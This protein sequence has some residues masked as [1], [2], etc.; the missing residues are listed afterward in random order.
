[1]PWC[2]VCCNKTNNDGIICSHDYINK[3]N[4]DKYNGLF[5]QFNIIVLNFHNN[6]IESSEIK[7]FL[8]QL[9]SLHNEI[10]KLKMEER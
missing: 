6:S 8:L 10:G 1:M 7:S 4:L 9:I 3:D 5:Y 2:E